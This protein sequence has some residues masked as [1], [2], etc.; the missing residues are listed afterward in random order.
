MSVPTTALTMFL[1]KRLAVISKYQVVGEV[2]IHR[3]AVTWQM[4]V[5]M[6]KML[7]RLVHLLEIQGIVHLQ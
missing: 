3:A 6:Q 7:S 5:V 4:V 1:R 2:C